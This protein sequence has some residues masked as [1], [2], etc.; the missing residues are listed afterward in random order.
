MTML[1]TTRNDNDENIIQIIA[2]TETTLE[3][4]WIN[5]MAINYANHV[6]NTC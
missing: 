6:D 2:I 1:V 4:Q 5:I 3:Y